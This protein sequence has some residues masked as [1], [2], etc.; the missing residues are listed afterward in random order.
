MFMNPFSKKNELDDELPTYRFDNAKPYTQ[1]LAVWGSPGSGKTVLSTKLAQYLASHRKDV[2]LVYCDAVTPMMHCVD[3]PNNLVELHSLGS[4]L[5]AVHPSKSLIQENFVLHKRNEHLFML[6]Y[7]KGE[8]TYSYPPLEADCAKEFLQALREFSTYVIVDCTSQIHDD[9]LS[10]VALMDA[11]CVLQVSSSDLKG[12]SYLN[13]QLPLLSGSEWNLDKY[14]KVAG[15]VK[16]NQAV[17]HLANAVK[18]IDYIIP[19]SDE[20]EQQYLAG[21]LFRDLTLKESRLFRT[22]IEKIGKEVLRV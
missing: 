5:S 7:L 2:I 22:T 11:D 9:A 19:Y 17:D 16:G 18:G 1:V 13:S 15:N 20:V 21:N 12:I 8:N 3:H 10:A 6:G 14:L 4:I